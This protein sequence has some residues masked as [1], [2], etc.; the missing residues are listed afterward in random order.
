MRS[1]VG[2]DDAE[3]GG[4]R[5]WHYIHA[6][7]LIKGHQAAPMGC[8]QGQQ[9]GIGD[10]TRAQKPLPRDQA[11][12]QKADRRRPEGMAGVPAGFRKAFATRAAG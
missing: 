8:R 10:L 9:V 2:R 4:A 1:S 3:V 5:G 6:D 12:L 11:L 7:P